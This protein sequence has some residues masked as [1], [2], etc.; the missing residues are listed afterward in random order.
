MAELEEVATNIKEIVQKIEG[1]EEVST[2]QDEK[3]TVHSLVVDPTKGNTEEIAQQ[4]GVM[5]NKTPIG[6]ISLGDKQKTVFLEPLLETDTP[7]DL[8]NIPVMTDSGIVPVS[9]I[10]TLQSEEL[11]TNQFHKDGDAYL[12][13]T[14]SVDAAKLSEISD[15]VNLE[16]FGDQ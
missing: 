7:E 3:K 2:N 10:A 14:A 12:R 9:S 15:T 8:E 6:T 4:L 16:I 13:V 1:V 5:L 11:S